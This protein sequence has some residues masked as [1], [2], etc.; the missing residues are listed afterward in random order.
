MSAM[1]SQITGVS[2]VYLA[3]SSGADQ[4]RYQSC[5]SLAFL[6]GI[7]QWQY[8][9]PHKVPVTRKIFPFDDIIMKSPLNQLMALYRQVTNPL[10]EPVLT[11]IYI[12]LWRH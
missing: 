11:Q 10:H 2:I 6:R 1:A 4:M 3:V 9:S 8:N 7:H 5:A 12:A